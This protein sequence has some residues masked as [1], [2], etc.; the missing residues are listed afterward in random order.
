MGAE[1]LFA[2]RGGVMVRAC[3]EG[4]LGE[5]L[6]SPSGRSAA[7]ALGDFVF[8]AG[9]PERGLLEQ[10]RGDI[11]VPLSGGWAEEIRALYGPRAAQFVRFAFG[12]APGAEAAPRLRELAAPPEGFELREMD[13]ELWE[14]CRREAWSRDLAAEHWGSWGNFRR[15]ALGFLAL[16]GGELAAGAS[17]YAACQ[18]AI[19]VQVDTR[20][21]LRRRHL[22]RCCAAKLALGCA[23]RGLYPDWDAHTAA[24]AALAEGLGYGGRRPYSAFAVGR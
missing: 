7:A 24:S 12:S 6:V 8:L 5:V 18:G 17:S 9:A 13:E 10:S 21:D 22:A 11:L 1:G 3:L 16:R 19:E 20:A 15:R 4:E 2:G 23:E 14:L